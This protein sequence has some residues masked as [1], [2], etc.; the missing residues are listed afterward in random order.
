MYINYCLEMNQQYYL[1]MMSPDQTRSWCRLFGAPY[2]THKVWGVVES[3]L[4]L[5]LADIPCHSDTENLPWFLPALFLT[6]CGLSMILLFLKF[7]IRRTNSSLL[8]D[9]EH[10]I[11]RMHFPD[12]WML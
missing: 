3:Q 9:K 5:F 2:W 10:I 12:I 6:T 7:N 8:I 1:G 4:L 11:I